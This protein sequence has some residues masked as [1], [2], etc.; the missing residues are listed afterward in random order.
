VITLQAAWLSDRNSKSGRRIG[1]LYS[2]ACRLTVA[3]IQHPGHWSLIH[4]V[5]KLKVF[6]SC[7]CICAHPTLLLKCT[8]HVTV[9]VTHTSRLNVTAELQ[10]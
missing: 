1:F 6:W 4:R 5:P 9:S 2:T 3:S 7:A 8:Y 10:Q